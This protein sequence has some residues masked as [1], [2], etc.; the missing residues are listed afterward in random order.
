MEMLNKRNYDMN[1]KLFFF[2]THF[3]CLLFTN[4]KK[5]N[6][7]SVKKWKQ[8]IDIFSMKK[9]FFPIN[10]SECHW[11]FV[12]INFEMKEIQYYDSLDYLGN[13]FTKV[14]YKW[15]Q[16]E[17]K[18]RNI[19]FNSNDWKLQNKTSPIQNNTI[20]C[21]VFTIMSIDFLSD[22]LL[23]TYSQDDITFFRKK[24]LISIINGSLNYPFY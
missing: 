1:R 11:A 3:I 22:D 4:L 6:Y 17:A 14:L 19:I 20:D 8:K 2:P 21:G 12:L 9:I 5:Y 16:D 18:N 10:I 23:L 24:I 13:K 7:N 15:L